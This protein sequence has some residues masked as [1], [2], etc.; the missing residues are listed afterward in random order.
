MID[1]DLLLNGLKAAFASAVLG[2]IPLLDGC[3]LS[4]LGL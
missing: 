3:D 2:S 4:A 1:F